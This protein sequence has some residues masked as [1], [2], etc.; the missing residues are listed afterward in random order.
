MDWMISP[1]ARALE[2]H[3]SAKAQPKRQAIVMLD[4]YR[5]DT[6]SAGQPAPILAHEG[7]GF[8]LGRWQIALDLET[9]AFW[10]PYRRSHF[11]APAWLVEMAVRCS[12]SAGRR[13]PSG[14]YS[15]GITQTCC[16]RPSGGWHCPSDHPSRLDLSLIAPAIVFVS[17]G[18]DLV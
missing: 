14:P 7:R 11:N 15:K 8:G 2:V 1:V 16:F 17:F 18:G 9:V 10:D 4:E 6:E 13:R 12:A 5:T 3:T